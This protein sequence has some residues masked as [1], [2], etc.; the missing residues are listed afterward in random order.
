MSDDPLLT[1][2][3]VADRLKI[4]AS[5]VR[6]LIRTKKLPAYALGGG[7]VRPLLRV[8]ASAVEQMLQQAALKDPVGQSWD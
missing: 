5:A 2:A 4:S 3:Q 1:V 7:T 6:N 8:R